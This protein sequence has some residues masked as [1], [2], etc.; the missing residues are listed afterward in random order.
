MTYVPLNRWIVAHTHRT[1]S[2]SRR[3][4]SA[5]SRSPLLE[6]S[7]REICPPSVST[8]A[9]RPVASNCPV[10]FEKLERCLICVPAGLQSS[11]ATR[12]PWTRDRLGYAKD[13]RYV[14]SFS[15][16]LI[17]WLVRYA[18]ICNRVANAVVLCAD[19]F[20][21][22]GWKRYSYTD[23]SMLAHTGRR[24][25]GRFRGPVVAGGLACAVAIKL[26]LDGVREAG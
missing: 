25:C 3:Q 8:M 13:L 15:L 17:Q 11:T 7:W 12:N 2:R 26:G 24:S 1:A 18:R 22:G 20:S 9:N 19:A 16:E 5:G 21:L 4:Q 6:A 14:R 10:C 23:D